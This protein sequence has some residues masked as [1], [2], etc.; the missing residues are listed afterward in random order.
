MST[1]P[2]KRFRVAIAQETVHVIIIEAVDEETAYAQAEE[3]YQS[4]EG[5]LAY[6]PPIGWTVDYNPFEVCECEEVLS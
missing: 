5:I 3:R 1:L 6:I 2:L 4:D